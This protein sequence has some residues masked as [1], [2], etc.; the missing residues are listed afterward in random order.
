VPGYVVL[1]EDNPLRALLY[2]AGRLGQR[3]ED[4]RAG[5]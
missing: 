3:V 4:A 2:S 1:Y 5:R